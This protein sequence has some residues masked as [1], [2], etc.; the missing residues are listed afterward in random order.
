MRDGETFTSERRRDLHICAVG[1]DRPMKRF[2]VGSFADFTCSEQVGEGTYGFVYKAVDKR[3]NEVVALKKMIIHKEMFGFPL[4]AVREIKFL[5]SLHHKNLVKLLDIVSAKSVEYLEDTKVHK[6][7][8]VKS[9]TETL[10]TADGKSSSHHAKK[11]DGR[12]KKDGD[13]SITSSN[14]VTNSSDNKATDEENNATSQS[15]NL[16]L[17]SNIYLV[18]EYIEH[19]LG[20]LVD[21]KYK[22]TLREIKSIMKQLFE[23][24]DYLYERKIVHRDI[25]T[26]NILI[27][28]NH[29]IKLADF[30]LARSLIGYDGKEG[31]LDLT[32]NVITM[33]YKPPELLLGAVRYTYSVDV[34]STGCVC[35][36]LELGRPLFPGKTE[37]Q[38]LD[39][40]FRSIGTPDDDVWNA[41]A[42]MLGLTTD[43]TSKMLKGLPRYVSSLKQ[44]YSKQI[45]DQTLTFLERVL[46]S[47]PTKRS[48]ARTAL[49]SSYFS[50]Q[51][52]PPLDPEDLGPLNITAGASLHEYQT[53]RKRREEIDAAGVA[54]SAAV[55]AVP[56]APFQYGAP[57]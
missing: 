52:L 16:S 56:A 57:I 7:Q 11:S 4:C 19:D 6:S 20:G 17:C 32:N 12:S 33:W 49:T 13:A 3:N 31:K 15:I 55:A 26:S 37:V 2:G 50:T 51:P 36:E 43:G 30:G 34:W 9:T 45:C 47:D 1:I 53:K 40:I 28:N 29:L 41:N 22:F 23:V 48:S 44:S 18:F 24:V 10:Q 38:Q 46:V 14:K 42:T 25:K 35:A 8:V 27:S 21:A 54:A 5:K 39:L